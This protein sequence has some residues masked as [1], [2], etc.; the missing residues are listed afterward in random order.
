MNSTS[1]SSDVERFRTLV[2]R[3]LGLDFED[4]KLTFLSDVLEQRLQA[5][6]LLAPEYLDRHDCFGSRE[7]V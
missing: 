1:A 6:K 5:S 7:E 4:A 3:R 2:R